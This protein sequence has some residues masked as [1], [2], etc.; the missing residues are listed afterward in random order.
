MAC[1]LIQLVQRNECAV[2]F[3]LFNL[4]RKS[5]TG[6]T[7]SVSCV[8]QSCV[9]FIDDHKESKSPVNGAK[10]YDPLLL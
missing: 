10:S 8:L 4:C 1:L 5:G 6:L 9:Q 2:M 7:F 3:L